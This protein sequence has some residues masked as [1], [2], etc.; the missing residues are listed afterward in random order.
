MYDRKHMFGIAMEDF[1]SCTQR[2]SHQSCPGSFTR[3][4]MRQMMA[5]T[6][7]ETFF[8]FLFVGLFCVVFLVFH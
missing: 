4:I 2:M 6:F 7:W 5:G 1:F 8:L 3:A